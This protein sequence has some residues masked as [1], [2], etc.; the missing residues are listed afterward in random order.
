M[1]VSL[2]LNSDRKLIER[3]IITFFDVLSYISGVEA[4]L[5]TVLGLIASPFSH[6]NLGHYLAQRLYQ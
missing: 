1:A 6:D 5:A 4:I 3:D 2:E